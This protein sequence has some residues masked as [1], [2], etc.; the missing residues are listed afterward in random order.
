MFP[1]PAWAV[2]S[3]SS[4]PPAA[5]TVGTKS[6]GG[7]HQRHGSPCTL[8][9]YKQRG[10]RMQESRRRVRVKRGHHRRVAEV[11]PYSRNGSAA[12]RRIIRPASFRARRRE[13]TT[14]S[15]RPRSST[16][17]R[18][19]ARRSTSR[20]GTVERRRRPGS[21]CS[22]TTRPTVWRE[23]KFFRDRTGVTWTSR[24]SPRSP[25]WPSSR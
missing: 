25:F 12:A 24:I 9:L 20:S 1:H 2:G 18:P 16:R 10:R 14:S 19:R 22:L 8:V 21:S 6:T 7:F 15:S 4:G 5:K 3:Y 17:R 11:S 13:S 23:A